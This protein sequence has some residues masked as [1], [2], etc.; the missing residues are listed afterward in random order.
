MFFMWGNAD[1]HLI[2]SNLI[3]E[4]MKWKEQERTRHKRKIVNSVQL[5]LTAPQ[6]MSLMLNQKYSLQR[7]FIEAPKIKIFTPTPILYKVICLPNNISWKYSMVKLLQDIVLWS[8][9][10]V[11]WLVYVIDYC[12]WTF[13]MESIWLQDWAV[14]LYSV[15]FSQ[16]SSSTHV[17]YLS[18]ELA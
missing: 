2:W 1:L 12:D 10:I 11:S 18:E 9:C 15:S 3:N 5:L 4:I 8:G 17:T 16:D 14:A 13:H 7:V 6:T